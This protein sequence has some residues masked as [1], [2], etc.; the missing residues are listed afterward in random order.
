MATSKLSDTMIRVILEA[1][2][3]R[4]T[5][6]DGKTVYQV[7]C[8]ASTTRALQARGK[9]ETGAAKE[10]RG[11]NDSAWFASTN[12][13]LTDECVAFLREALT[14]VLAKSG[15]DRDQAYQ[16]VIASSREQSEAVAAFMLG[17]GVES[18]E[19]VGRNRADSKEDFREQLTVE[20][21]VGQLGNIL[22]NG[23]RLTFSDDGRITMWTRMTMNVTYIPVKGEPVAIEEVRRSFE[24]CMASM[25]GTNNSSSLALLMKRAAELFRVLDTRKA[26]RGTV[27]VAFRLRM[28]YAL[29]TTHLDTLAGYGRE[30]AEM[31]EERAE[32]LTAEY[33]ALVD[34]LCAAEMDGVVYDVTRHDADGEHP[35]PEQDGKRLALEVGIKHGDGARVKGDADLFVVDWRGVQGG[36]GEMAFS[37]RRRSEGGGAPA[38]EPTPAPVTVGDVVDAPHSLYVGGALRHAGLP[39]ERVRTFVSNLRFKKK[40]FWQDADGAICVEDR[41]YVPERG[42]ASEPTPAPAAV[43]VPDSQG[44]MVEP[45]EGARYRMFVGV[46]RD[47]AKDMGE[48]SAAQVRT[49]IMN[50]W[51]RGNHAQPLG[52]GVIRVGYSFFEPVIDTAGHADVAPGGAQY[53]FAAAYQ[54]E[55][56][57]GAGE[58]VHPA[59]VI[60]GEQA[61]RIVGH[62]TTASVSYR[63][64]GVIVV[65]KSPTNIVG[66]RTVVLTPLELSDVWDVKNEAGDVLAT[67]E[68]VFVEEA[69]REAYR[70]PVVRE[71]AE[72]EGGVSMRCRQRPVEAVEPTPAP[73]DVA[74]PVLVPREPWRGGQV[75][76]YQV[77]VGRMGSE[78][79][80]ERK[81]PGRAM[82]QRHHD[83]VLAEYGEV[84]MSAGNELGYED[85]PFVLLWEPTGGDEPVEPTE[86]ERVAFERAHN[87]AG[88][89]APAAAVEPVVAPEGPAVAVGTVQAPWEVYGHRVFGTG[90]SVPMGRPEWT[91]AELRCVDCGRVAHLHAFYLL[92]CTDVRELAA[93]ERLA[94]LTL[95]YAARYEHRVV[96]GGV[97]SQA[98]ALGRARA[99]ALLAAGITE[100]GTLEGFTGGVLR[101]AFGDF[102]TTFRPLAG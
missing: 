22:S 39:S 70:L 57:T 17:D 33:S 20:D 15:S 73:V 36:P 23:Q 1:L 62:H 63:A 47:D 40:E 44:E 86:A 50:G 64:G 27:P 78:Y 56:R 49:A 45:V 32:R 35:C 101:M 12:V 51:E 98:L 16:D 31:W 28:Q 7:Q 29:E 13:W 93:A 6:M 67:V 68:G 37:Y 65:T 66:E 76:G 94:E 42:G 92:N 10:I 53:V 90:E 3:R 75:C 18:V 43:A 38:A 4:F 71:T 26:I 41:R 25:T 74:V 81:A 30:V 5:T 100:G 2:T 61:E 88:A 59:V 19:T 87:L 46:L 8:S 89:E 60:E 83:E 54:Q 102:E 34:S 77:T 14:V 95:P 58:L 48:V 96:R 55:V 91:V 80:G 85:E 21:A 82:C 52:D 11:A 97:E 79:C 69:R 99:V 9:V 24:T 72:R 84:R